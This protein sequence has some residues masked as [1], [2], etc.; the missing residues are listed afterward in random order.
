MMI[1]GYIFRFAR[2]KHAVLSAPATAYRETA[3]YA[4]WSFLPLG[5]PTAAENSSLTAW[6]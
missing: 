2:E 5:A 3:V 6:C 4:H 1:H